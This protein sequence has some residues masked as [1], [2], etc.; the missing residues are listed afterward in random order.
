MRL[1]NMSRR[2]RIRLTALAVTLAAALSLGLVAVGATGAYF[3]DTHNGAVAGTIGSIKVTTSGGSGADGLD[4]SF[5]NLLPG[6]PQ[7]AVVH[8]TNS[9]NNAEDVYLKFPN[10]TALSALNNLGT[11]GEVHVVANG[12]EVFA[13]TN[14]NDRSATCGAFSTTGCWPLPQTLKVASNVAPGHSGTIK[15]TFNYASKMKTQPA[16]GTTAEFNT[17]PVPAGQYS[18]SNPDG[19]TT[20]NAADGTGSGL[21]IQ[22]V[23]VQV[24][25]TP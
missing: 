25:Q 5:A 18:P 15:F 13:S 3:S 24:G 6:E 9:G 14:L 12:T 4:F 8:Y 19:Q 10:A 2:T 7:T 20:V 11:Y 1:R 22:I 23:A 21:P 17:Y 16:A